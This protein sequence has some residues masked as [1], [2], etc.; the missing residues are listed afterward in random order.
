M[1]NFLVSAVLLGGGCV[2][3]D[4]GDD[5]DNPPHDPT[6]PTDPT[7]PDDPPPPPPPPSP[8]LAGAYHLTTVM[9]LSATTVV[10]ATLHQAIDALRAFGISPGN[11]LFDLAAEAGVPAVQDIR[12]ALPDF[13]EA[14]VIEWIDQRLLAT[15]LPGVANDLVAIADTAFG[16]VELGSRLDIE[17]PLHQLESI[18]VVV[19]GHRVDAAVEALPEDAAEL[20]LSAEPVCTMNDLSLTIGEHR[21]GLRVGSLMWTAL[22]NA[23][24]TGWGTDVQTVL[25]DAVG[26]PAMAAWVADQC[27]WG[28]C[29]GHE[30]ELNQICDAGVAKAIDKLRE[31]ITSADFDAV[32]LHAGSATGTDADDDLVAETLTGTWTAEIDVGA[33]LRPV[34]ASFEGSAE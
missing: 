5:G 32:V 27:M 6:D 34:P 22:E 21:F 9:D 14:K 8:A 25:S 19:D 23:V 10:P 18:A 28:Y 30:T 11:A 2:V 29:V 17:A 4:D 15:G 33:G 20:G 24:E 1:R 12:D 16:H 26:C 31:Q 3:A 7:D 13:L